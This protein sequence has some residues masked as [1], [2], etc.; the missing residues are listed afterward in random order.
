MDYKI[1]RF[2]GIG[3]EVAR[4][5]FSRFCERT[6]RKF[7]M[8]MEF[9]KEER[10]RIF[11]EIIDCCIVDWENTN[12]DGEALECTRANKLK[13]LKNASGFVKFIEVCLGKL[14]EKSSKGGTE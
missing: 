10:E 9:T 8:D 7:Y 1:P 6:L 2:D 14:E 11:E 5:N 13:L 3:R 4:N 12:L